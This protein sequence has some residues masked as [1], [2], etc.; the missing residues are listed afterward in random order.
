MMKPLALATLLA[1]FASAVSAAAAADG[2]DALR[3]AQTVVP[4][5]APSTGS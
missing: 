1:L 2:C 4:P 3:Q 5:A